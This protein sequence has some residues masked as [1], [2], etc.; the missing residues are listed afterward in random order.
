MDITSDERVPR[1]L[2]HTAEKCRVV[3]KAMLKA[4]RERADECERKAKGIQG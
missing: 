1:E 2:G 3:F 4:E